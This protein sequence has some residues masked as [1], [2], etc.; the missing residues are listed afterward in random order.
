[1]QSGRYTLIHQICCMVNFVMMVIINRA[2]DNHMLQYDRMLWV[3]EI[4]IAI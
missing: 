1:M 2:N 4:C 3:R